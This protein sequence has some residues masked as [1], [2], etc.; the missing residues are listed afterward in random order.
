MCSSDLFSVVFFVGLGLMRE[1]MS[2]EGTVSGEIGGKKSI[3]SDFLSEEFIVLFES[4]GVRRSV[5]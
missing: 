1:V 3:G 5:V 2:E 4:D